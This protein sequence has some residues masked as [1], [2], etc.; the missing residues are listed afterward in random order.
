MC[1]ARVEP[2]HDPNCPG[3]APGAQKVV[4]YGST[5]LRL[6]WPGRGASER[7]AQKATARK[8]TVEALYN[9][10]VRFARLA[11]RLLSSTALRL[12]SSL[13]LAGE[14]ASEQQRVT[15]STVLESL[16]YI[17]WN[18]IRESLISL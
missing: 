12:Y 8:V 1:R 7:A 17:S 9:E 18:L 13:G 4:F 6:P 11:R 15:L 14:R 5:A 16:D 2:L 3:R 10:S